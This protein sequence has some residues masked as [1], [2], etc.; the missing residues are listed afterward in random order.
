MPSGPLARLGVPLPVVVAPMAGGPS[1]PELVAAVGEAGALG[2]LA[3]GYRSAVQLEAQIA[4]TRA[5]TDRPFG[6][7]VFV[8]GSSS[9]DV[10][11]LDRYALRLAPVAQRLGVPL[12]DG[13][14][15]DDGY[16]GKLELLVAARVPMV[17]FT[18]GCPSAQD[19]ERLHGAG[20]LVAVTV[21]SPAEAVQAQRVG[22]DALVAQGAEAG[23]HQG[24][25]DDDPHTPLGGAAR[26]LATLLAELAPTAPPPVI[27]AGGLMTG[28]DIA[29]AL[30]AGAVAGQLGTAFLCC[31]EAGTSETHRR[32]LADPRFTATAFTRAFTGRT[33]RGLVN[34]FL[35]EHTA[36]AP[37][38][39]PWVHHLTRPLRAAAAER[40]DAD[41]VH[42]WTGQGWRDI[43][44][45]PAAE[46]VATLAVELAAAR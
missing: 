19:V 35:R 22:A 30:A 44:P 1:T 31:P 28:A 9:V 27:A 7:N 20:S 16:A 26:P 4:R 25:F 14:W 15:D 24:C 23:G 38:A 21:T 39:Y 3:A 12:G 11:A 2:F 43:R 6:V 32:A 46:L 42:L 13:R 18:F 41:T 40:G 10:A 33:A 17:A 45:L 29:G 5:L 36:D 34:D 37:A 8:P